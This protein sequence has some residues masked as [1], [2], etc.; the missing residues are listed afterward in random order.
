MTL[1]RVLVADDFA[2]VLNAVS[3]LF[4]KSFDVVCLT[5]DGNSALEG[6]LKHEPD[7]AVLDISM[8]GMSG[9][10]VAREVKRRGNKAKIVFLTS[11][12]DPDI[13][14]SCL[15]AGGVGYVVK[16]FMATDL[17][18]AMNAALASSLFVSRFSPERDTP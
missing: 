18:P 3:A 10:E 9:F 11:H 2:P 5:S 4:L 7:I 16:M 1:K 12:Q 17:I 6:V 15:E 14:A 13:L 8:P